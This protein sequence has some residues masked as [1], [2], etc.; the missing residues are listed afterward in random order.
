[1]NT[2]LLPVRYSIVYSPPGTIASFYFYF[3]H[4]NNV[5]VKMMIWYHISLKSHLNR[6]QNT[7]LFF[8]AEWNIDGLF[9]FYF[10]K[11][12]YLSSYNIIYM[13][14][15]TRLLL[16]SPCFH[17]LVSPSASGLWHSSSYNYHKRTH[18]G[19]CWI[20]VKFNRTFSIQKKYSH[21]GKKLGK[22]VKSLKPVVWSTTEALVFH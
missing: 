11:S 9:F 22:Q 18:D 2:C 19:L 10:K 16:W 17:C 6:P 15:F 5:Q 1:M 21:W 14:F 3:V 12:R 4:T 8:V 7:N 13:C 20:K